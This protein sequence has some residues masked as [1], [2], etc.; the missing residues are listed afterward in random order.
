[1]SGARFDG[2]P[3]GTLA[4][5]VRALME[6]AAA[7]VLMPL[8]RSAGLAVDH[9]AK[10]E[11]VTR[12]DRESE[13]LL[14]EALERLLPGAAVIGE[15]GVAADPSRMAAIGGELAWIVDP[16]DGTGNFA[17]GDERFGVMVALAERGETVG[18]FIFQPVS[19]RHYWAVRGQ[20]AFVDDRP[21]R[22]A[23]VAARP[24]VGLSA[25]WG[26]GDERAA[27]ERSLAERFAFQPLPRC[28]AVVYPELASGTLDVACFR[29]TLPW[30]HAAGAL[31][32]E[33]AGGTVWRPD[34]RAYRPDQDEEGLFAAADEQVASAVRAALT[35]E[36]HG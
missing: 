33:E 36:R 17:A 27:I 16:L 6:R 20:G 25:L 2:G 32:V 10:G 23:K 14:A 31:L 13:A 30:D 7:D 9:K 11:P 35:L 5:S 29:R 19:G 15:E 21:L 8:W 22:V 24:R 28:A 1:M 26:S 34:G 4:R 18:G 12:A 3:D